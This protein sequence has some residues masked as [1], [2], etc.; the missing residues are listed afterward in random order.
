MCKK[1]NW[2]KK[3][4]S[5]KFWAMTTGVAVSTM[6]VFDVNQEAITKVTGLLTSVSV[7]IAY[8]LAESSVDKARENNRNLMDYPDEVW[9]DEL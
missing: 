9:H 8:I 4:S 3:L 6:V 2:R 1:I 7:L 5:R